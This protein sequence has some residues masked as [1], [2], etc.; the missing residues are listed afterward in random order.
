V[1]DLE[2]LLHR[3]R[4]AAGE[5]RGL[6][7][8][9]HGRGA[10]MHDL[11]PLLDALDPTHRFVGITPQ[12]PLLLPPGGHH[13]FRAPV[14]GQPD[15][16]TFGE[17]YLLLH[18]WLDAAQAEHGFRPAETLVG[19]FS[20]GAAMTY[21]LG[22]EREQPRLAGLIA[23]SGYVP[24]VPGHELD[25]TEVAGYPVAIGHGTEDDVIPVEH[26]RAARD[27]LLAAHAAV[28]Y[29]ESPLG[30]TIDPRFLVAL[31]E[32]ID[33]LWDETLL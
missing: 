11:F 20:Q 5:A 17:S 10:D 23:L 7:V 9:L 2:L 12:A 3:T 21:A 16:R 29:R 19:G 25:L 6:L 22:L 26:G 4:R 8:L 27:R 14:A 33:G 18:R 24:D 31:R 32:W 1:S 13:W 28:L 15:P 30:H